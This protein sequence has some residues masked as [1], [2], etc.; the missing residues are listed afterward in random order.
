M[1]KLVKFRKKLI[2]NSFEIKTKRRKEN[3]ELLKSCF[4]LVRGF[5]QK[6]VQYKS[7]RFDWNCYYKLKNT[8]T[9]YDVPILLM[10]KGDYGLHHDHTSITNTKI[11]PLGIGINFN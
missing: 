8:L 10:W 11:T 5:S 1:Y 3:F 7:L 9:P 4:Y 2:K 6:G